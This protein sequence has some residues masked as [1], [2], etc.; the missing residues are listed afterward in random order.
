MTKK[1]NISFEEQAVQLSGLIDQFLNSICELPAYE[2]CVSKFQGYKDELAEQ[3]STFLS[4]P[5]YDSEKLKVLQERAFQTY[6][7]KA[8]DG[9]VEA[10]SAVEDYLKVSDVFAGRKGH[11]Q[12]FM[13]CLQYVFNCLIILNIWYCFY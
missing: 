11:K 9:L 12:G 5:N 1:K 10:K 6:V 4:N 8:G 2:V 3:L 7:K 13:E